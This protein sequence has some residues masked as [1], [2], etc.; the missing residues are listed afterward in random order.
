MDEV[1]GAEAQVHVNLADKK[2][3]QAALDDFLGKV[4]DRPPRMLLL[5]VSGHGVQTGEQLYLVPT[6][7]SPGNP[8]Q[9]SEQCLSHGEIFR[10]FKAWADK[11]NIED[12]VCVL[13]IDA[14]RSQLGGAQRQEADVIT[15]PQRSGRTQWD[16]VALPRRPLC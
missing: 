9:L 16:R 1:P 6:G 14:C 2:A 8:Q 13:I 3:M 12:V 10:A 15:L 11:V 4:S 7:A 5:Y